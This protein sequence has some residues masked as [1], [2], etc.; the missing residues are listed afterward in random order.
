MTQVHWLLPANLLAES[1]AVMRPHGAKGSEGLALWLGAAHGSRIEVTHIVEVFGPGFVTTPLYMNLSLRA[2][3]VLT[4]LA[5]RLGTYLI[6]Q[7]HSHPENLLDLSDLDIRQGIRSPDYLSV[8][9]PYYAQKPLTEYARC[10]VHVFEGSRYRRL[11]PADISSR[12]LVGD[13]R[14]TR[15]KC[16]VPA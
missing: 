13:T 1:I 12:L 2:M 4:D 9:C 16:E 10:G 7:I 6:G 3:S 14:V 11:R 8:V 5:D 15:I